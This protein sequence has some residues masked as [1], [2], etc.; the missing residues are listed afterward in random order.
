MMQLVCGTCKEPLDSFRNFQIDDMASCYECYMNHRIGHNPLPRPFKE[1]RPRTF[2]K[3][4]PKELE[5]RLGGFIFGQAGMTG[6]L[7]Q[8]S[9]PGITTSKT[10]VAQVDNFIKDPMGGL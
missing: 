7:T 5:S 1:P 8:T 9:V 6:K 10:T 4:L 3:K 2:L